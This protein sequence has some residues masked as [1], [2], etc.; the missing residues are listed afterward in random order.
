MFVCTEKQRPI[1]KTVWLFILDSVAVY[2]AYIRDRF[3]M[4]VANT[5]FSFRSMSHSYNDLFSACLSVCVCVSFCF[6]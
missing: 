3:T 5:A 1:S 2:N 4:K 6:H